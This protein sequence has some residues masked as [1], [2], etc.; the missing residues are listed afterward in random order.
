MESEIRRKIDEI[1][2]KLHHELFNVD[3]SAKYR[4]DWHRTDWQ[5]LSVPGWVEVHLEIDRL[6]E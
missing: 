4:T 2:K 5:L 3:G 6:I 1:E